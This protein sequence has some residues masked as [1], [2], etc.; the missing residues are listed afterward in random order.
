MPH[1][2][3]ISDFLCLVE[4]NAYRIEQTA[5]QQEHKSGPG[6]N[7]YNTLDTDEHRPAHKQIE[8]HRGLGK[9][10]ETDGI[11]NYT[12]NS[13]ECVDA[14]KCPPHCAL[15]HGKTYGSVGTQYEKEYGAVVKNSE[16]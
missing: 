8:N 14:K 13:A 12:H 16:N 11:E 10:F 2:V 3:H 7:L 1:K 4:Y 9:L 15:D 5:C 6:Y